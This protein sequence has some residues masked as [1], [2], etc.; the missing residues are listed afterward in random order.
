MNLNT[1]C[2][3]VTPLNTT[4]MQKKWCATCRKERDKNSRIRS[5]KRRRAEGYKMPPKKNKVY[6]SEC[7]NCILA[8]DCSERVKRGIDCYCWNGPETSNRYFYLYEKAQAA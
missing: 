3:C 6:V 2:A 7:D 5:N 4:N 8:I 1:K